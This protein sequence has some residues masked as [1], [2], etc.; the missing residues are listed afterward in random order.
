MTK[1]NTLF[2]RQANK[3]GENLTLQPAEAVPVTF[4]MDLHLCESGTCDY[5]WPICSELP[6]DFSTFIMHNC[7]EI[8]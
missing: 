1:E 5:D 2:Q 8:R 6:E 7:A 3:F 4:H